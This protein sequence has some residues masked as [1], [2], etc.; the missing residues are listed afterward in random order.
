MPSG[1]EET[2]STPFPGSLP[3]HPR[4]AAPVHPP[5]RAVA[6]LCSR[7][8]KHSGEALLRVHPSADFYLSPMM[9]SPGHRVGQDFYK[10]ADPPCPCLD[11][12]LSAK[13]LLCQGSTGTLPG[14]SESLCLSQI[15]FPA[16]RSG[17]IPMELERSPPRGS[18]ITSTISWDTPWC[19][20]WVCPSLGCCSSGAPWALLPAAG[21][22][23]WKTQD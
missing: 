18:P 23:A 21:F 20:G 5:H 7:V 15:I 12:T 2:P 9:V 3:A 6:T 13:S 4:A 8:A 22:S 16:E 10:H 14:V 1:A 11:L 19:L 17:A